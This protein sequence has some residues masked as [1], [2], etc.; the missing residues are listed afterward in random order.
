MKTILVPTDF[1]KCSLNALNFAVHI[2]KQSGSKIHLTH[3]VHVPIDWAYP[4][5][6]SA[7]S[8]ALGYDNQGAYYPTMKT[9]EQKAKKQLEKLKNTITK[10]GVSVDYSVSY[11]FMVTNV[12]KTAKK[13]NAGMVVM[14]TKGA[15]GMKEMLIGS[16][17]EKVIRQSETSVLV[18]P[19]KFKKTKIKKLLFATNFELLKNNTLKKLDEAR[20]LFKADVEFLY[21]NVPNYFETSFD[22]ENQKEKFYKA[23]KLKNNPFYIYCDLSIDQGIVNF[24]KKDSADLIALETHGRSG[25]N[26]MLNG[27]IAE[28]VC[29][30]TEKAVLI[31]K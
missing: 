4:E 29:N 14:G 7:G 20:A 25:I 5:M 23:N 10:K 12:I 19:D 8:M 1:S 21:V 13:V 6:T 26:H 18:V 28:N 31:I 24:S 27:S 17:T 2:A 22:I 11:Q 9:V 16:N 3:S 15:S 30:H